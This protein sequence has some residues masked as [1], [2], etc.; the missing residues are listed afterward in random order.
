VNVIGGRDMRVNEAQDRRGGG[1]GGGG[2]Q[3]SRF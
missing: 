1:G 3:G 2:N